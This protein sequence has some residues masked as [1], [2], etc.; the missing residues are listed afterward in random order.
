MH[1]ILKK[2]EIYRMQWMAVL[3]KS[4]NYPI[5]FRTWLML[6]VRHSH[7][8][9]YITQF[10]TIFCLFV[11]WLVGVKWCFFV[12]Y[13]VFLLLGDIVSLACVWLQN[14]ISPEVIFISQI[15]NKI[16]LKKWIVWHYIIQRVYKSPTEELISKIKKI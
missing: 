5:Y 8:L 12:L 16:L 7:F 4:Q 15:G 14:L 3:W 13:V 10:S 6:V 9:S 11:W 2:K 1:I